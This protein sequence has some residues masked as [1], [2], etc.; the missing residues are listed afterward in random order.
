[1]IVLF[2]LLIITHSKAEYDYAEWCL[3][4]WEIYLEFLDKK[5]SSSFGNPKQNFSIET[6]G[7]FLT[8][9]VTILLSFAELVSL[10][11]PWTTK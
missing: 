4:N 9:A 11:L 1:M 6:T 2:I 7:T 8:I 5:F 10:P 3:I